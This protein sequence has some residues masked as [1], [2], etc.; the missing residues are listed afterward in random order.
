L[1]GEIIDWQAKHTPHN[2]QELQRETETNATSKE[3][4][5][6][7]S[8][9]LRQIFINIFPVYKKKICRKLCKTEEAGEESGWDKTEK[10]PAAAN[11]VMSQNSGALDD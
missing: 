10:I 7:N 11:M 9:R 6:Y 1:N 4:V 8:T 5:I 3:P 2:G